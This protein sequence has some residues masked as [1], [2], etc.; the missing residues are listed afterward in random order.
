M[1]EGK[2]NNSTFVF[3][4]GRLQLGNP[5]VLDFAILIQ[6][7]TPLVYLKTG[8]DKLNVGGQEALQAK[9]KAYSISSKNH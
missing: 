3:F 8:R 9:T 6:I 5:Q 7:A 1:T 4:A 2:K